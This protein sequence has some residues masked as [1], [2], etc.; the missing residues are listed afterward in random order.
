MGSGEGS[1]GL[2]W[3]LLTFQGQ[4]GTVAGGEV[5]LQEQ[6][7]AVR[8]LQEDIKV[9]EQERQ[10]RGLWD[11]LPEARSAPF[12]SGQQQYREPSHD[13]Y[14]DHSP[15]YSR[16][17][18]S[19]AQAHYSQSQTL[20]HYSQ[21][22]TQDYFSQSQ[23]QDYYS[24]PQAQTKTP[25]GFWG[26]II[27][28]NK[29][30][31]EAK[32]N[33]KPPQQHHE[34]G[35]RSQRQEVKARSSDKEISSDTKTSGSNPLGRIKS[36]LKSKGALRS[37][38]TLNREGLERRGEDYYEYQDEYDEDLGNVDMREEGPMDNLEAHRSGWKL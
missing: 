13:Y 37:L 3:L 38:H 19:Q 24:E 9:Q 11:S 7:K 10:G 12:H 29:E 35:R 36:L 4:G 34:G 21:P 17:S 33:K 14:S 5:T 22:Q 25:G 32:Q 28:T 8:T 15:D 23:T 30:A 6:G 20:D 16:Y 27:K 2:L 1:R 26:Q 31:E 18:D